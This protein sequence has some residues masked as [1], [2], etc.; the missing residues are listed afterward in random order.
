M[1]RGAGVFLG[2]PPRGALGD[3]LLVS[4]DGSYGKQITVKGDRK[5]I[6]TRSGGGGGYQ[7]VVLKHVVLHP[8][9]L[10][11]WDSILQGVT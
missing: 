3:G 8:C 9:T 1:I 10:R 2:H 7:E 5:V 6:S 4:E 11:G